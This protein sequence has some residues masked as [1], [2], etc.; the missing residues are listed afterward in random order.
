MRIPL[1]GG[2]VC[3]SDRRGFVLYFSPLFSEIQKPLEVF[4]IE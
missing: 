3:N 1:V 4:N 2:L